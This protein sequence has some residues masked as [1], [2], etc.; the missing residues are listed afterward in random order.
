MKKLDVSPEDCVIFEDS[1]TG[2]QAGLAAGCQL[3]GFTQYN[4]PK[5]PLAN[6]IATINNWGEI[7]YGKLKQLHINIK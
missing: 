6:V 1:L 5:E 7:S 3:I 2:I 4:P